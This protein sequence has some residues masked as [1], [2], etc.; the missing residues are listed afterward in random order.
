MGFG[1]MVFF[2]K[3]KSDEIPGQI[4]GLFSQSEVA[5]GGSGLEIFTRISS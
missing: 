3:N 4:F 2:H 1:I 5:L